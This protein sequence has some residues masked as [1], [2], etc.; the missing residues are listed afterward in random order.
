MTFGCSALAIEATQAKQL[1]DR[2]VI[3]F[4]GIIR[5]A[6][7]SNLGIYSRNVSER[8]QFNQQKLDCITFNAIR[9][10]TVR[11]SKRDFQVVLVEFMLATYKIPRVAF[12]HEIPRKILS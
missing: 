5:L 11:K 3:R 4:M 1:I 10:P 6:H 12:L 8:L 2:I 9:W 7:N